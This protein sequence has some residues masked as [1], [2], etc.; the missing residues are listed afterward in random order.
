MI[1]KASNH[2]L[3]IKSDLPEPWQILEYEIALNLLILKLMHALKNK[4][5]KMAWTR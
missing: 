4:P 3:K 2:V 5:K 1:N